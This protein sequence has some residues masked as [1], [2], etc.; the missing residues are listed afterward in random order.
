M[1]NLALYYDDIENNYPKAIEYYLMAIKK[2]DCDAMH[3]L[4]Y[5]YHHTKTN[6]PKAIEYYLMA[7]KNG[8]NNTISNLTEITTPLK[9]YILYLDNN[10]EYTQPITNEIQIYINK[11]KNTSREME[12]P[13]CLDTKTCVLLN[14]C[15]HYICS[16]CYSELYKK[17]CP[18]CRL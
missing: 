12:C 18:V 8:N 3:N 6:Y 15:T 5:Y 2:G 7:I 17:P 9:R 16:N 10:I 13:V 4:G 14:C 11:L 1:F